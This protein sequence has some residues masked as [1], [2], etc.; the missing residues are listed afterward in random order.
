MID[1]AL[2]EQ[3]RRLQE[4]LEEAVRAKQRVQEIRRE[5]PAKRRAASAAAP[6]LAGRG[7]RA[8]LQNRESVR[9]AIV[10]REVLGPP[11]GLRQDD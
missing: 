4:Q 3:Q 7:I 5:V 10:L 2:L 8:D 6:A 9:R 1:P 11:V